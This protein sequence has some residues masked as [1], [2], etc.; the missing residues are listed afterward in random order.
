MAQNIKTIKYF[1]RK[2]V[3]EEQTAPEDVKEAFATFAEGGDTMS[4]GQLREFVDKVQCQPQYTVEE[5]E[6]IMETF[7]RSRRDESDNDENNKKK[8]KGGDGDGN[9]NGGCCFT[10]EEFFQFLYFD[11]FNAPL[12]PEVHHDMD[13]PLSHYFINTG[14]NSY[15]TGNQLS[16]DC[17]EVPIIQALNKG[18]RVIE[19]DLWPNSNKTDIDVVHGRT[20]T[21]PVSLYKCLVAIK[22]NAFVASEY[23]VIITLEDHLTKDLQ[24][25]AAEVTN[26]IFGDLL[27]YPPEDAMDEFPSPESLKGRIL[28]STKP[29]PVD[30]LR[31]TFSKRLIKDGKESE[32]ESADE[33]LSPPPSIGSDVDACDRYNAS[34]DRE[35]E[36]ELTPSSEIH[37]GVIHY[38]RMI[39]IHAG[40]PKGHIK[41]SLSVDGKV[42]RLS[43]SEQEIERASSSYGDDLISFTQRNILRVY[44]KGTRVNSSN[45]RP[46]IGWLY[47]AQMVAMNMQGYGKSLWH[48][49]GLFRANGGSGYV[50]KPPLLMNKNDDGQS[51]I[52]NPKTPYPT[53]RIMKVKIYMGTGWISNFSKTHFD[54]FSPPD[55]YIKVSIH[56]VQYD[57][58]RHRTRVISD[59]WFPVWEEEFEIPL[60]V[61]S[62]ALV[63]IEAREYDKHEKDDFG[64]QTCFPVDEI[65]PGFRSVPLYDE[66]GNKY[67]HVKLLLRFQ[68]QHI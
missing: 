34:S 13:A 58:A 39:T 63:L 28:I 36:E 23:P 17:S 67:S 15:L 38:K 52:F 44:P 26:E 14:H 11:E 33:A 60:K 48:A 45:F 4:A 18:V 42:K 22:D 1:H 21:A 62:L 54:T 27:Y 57:K 7:L 49:Q 5:C 51:N 19:L 32:R 61:P 37:S 64:G 2:F 56:G 24:A 46:H 68:F 8:K 9:D 20:L 55:F 50:K 59:N 3:Q 43:L 53:S 66:K 30:E 40:K 65:R 35:C 31:D 12:S 25:L 6:R 47:G 10:L 41:D 16:S 29:P